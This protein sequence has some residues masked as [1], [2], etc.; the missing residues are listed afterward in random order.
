MNENG[1]IRSEYILSDAADV[2]RV[3][4][5]KDRALLSRDDVEKTANALTLDPEEAQ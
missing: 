3:I 4:H 2:D 1:L 5:V